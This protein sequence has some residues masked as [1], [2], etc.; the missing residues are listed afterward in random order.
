MS[1]DSSL[2]LAPREL[3]ED[4]PEF[5]SE[6]PHFS[7]PRIEEDIRVPWGFLD[8]V[9]FIVVAIVG[10]F[11]IGILVVGAFTLFGV[12]LAVIEQSGHEQ[13]LVSI[14]A[15]VII[16]LALLGF[17]A[18]QMRLRFREPFWRTIG[19]RPLDSGILPRWAA[20]TGL[21][22]AGVVISFLV[23]AA[24]NLHPPK[25]ALPIDAILQDR[26]NALLFLLM[27]VLLAPLVEETIFR[28]YIYPVIAKSWGVAA[29]VL[30]TG[31]LFGLLH[32]FQLGGALWQ[33]A[34]LIVVGI[35][36]TWVRA[37]A[38]T[39]VASYCLHV[40]YNSFLFVGFLA[41]THFLKTIPH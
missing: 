15:Q 18:L 35:I 10:T 1:S 8:L 30:I 28:G 29:S 9:I 5:S 20:Y 31:A 19:W 38:K 27:A 36:F 23:D 7:H 14:I 4:S 25:G 17:L 12:K 37:T 26:L 24:T 13:G 33:I 34:L 21:G 2:P 3:V 6:P 16:D 32:G 22:M 11:V 41:T 40:G 39:V